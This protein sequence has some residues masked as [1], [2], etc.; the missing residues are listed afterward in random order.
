MKYIKKLDIDF[1]DWDEP[2]KKKHKYYYGIIT[3]DHIE[4]Y[5]VDIDDDK[6]IYRF[7][8]NYKLNRLYY[9]NSYFLEKNDYFVFMNKLLKTGIIHYIYNVNIDKQ[10]LKKSLINT[11]EN[12]NVLSTW[13][14]DRYIN[15]FNNINNIYYNGEGWQVISYLH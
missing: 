11:I 8:D 5:P 13:S 1:N 9:N 3:Q 4:I 10:K 14:K 12:A 15:I 2:Q 6:E 7:G